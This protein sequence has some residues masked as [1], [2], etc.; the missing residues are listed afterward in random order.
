MPKKRQ[1]LLLASHFIFSECCSEVQ[2]DLY[3]RLSFASAAQVIEFCPL[4]LTYN[5]IQD[6]ALFSTVLMQL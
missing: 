2:S 6:Q 5:I 1:A 3:K 4:H